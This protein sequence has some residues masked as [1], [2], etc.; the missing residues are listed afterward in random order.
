MYTLFAGDGVHI[1]SIIVAAL[2]L[3]II[4]F[5]IPA[6]MMLYISKIYH[7]GL[8]LVQRDDGTP[9]G[10][11]KFRV[12]DEHHAQI[13][14]YE[15]G[16]DKTGAGSARETDQDLEEESVF[17]DQDAGDNV[18][19]RH[20]GSHEGDGVAI[21][22]EGEATPRRKTSRL[23]SKLKKIERATKNA[24]QLSKHAKAF[25]AAVLAPR[26]KQDA[27]KIRDY[28]VDMHCF[29][30]EQRWWW[31]VMLMFRKVTVVA[32]FLRG[33]NSDDNFDWRMALVRLVPCYR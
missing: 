7:S 24:K 8:E 26:G 16:H 1:F 28:F 30:R 20:S 12:P 29:Y 22:N 17:I 32:I 23:K 15:A 25:G 6:K 33:I 3:L 10:G 31:F 18:E 2:L 11:H 4:V 5:G 14:A 19:P 21:P 13:A 9:G 27:Q